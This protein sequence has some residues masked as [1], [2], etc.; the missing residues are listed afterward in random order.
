VEAA[1]R[2]PRGRA[3][4]LPN[5]PREWVLSGFRICLR[6]SVTSCTSSGTVPTESTTTIS[7]TTLSPRA[8]ERVS[9]RWLFP[10]S[11]R[12]PLDRRRGGGHRGG[13]RPVL[14]HARRI[15]GN[16]DE[17]RAARRH[18]MESRR[19][20]L[21]AVMSDKPS[22]SDSGRTAGRRQPGHHRRARVACCGR[23]SRR[24]PRRYT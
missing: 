8:S 14:Q 5:G 20:A 18:R 3:G 2:Q 19:P 15:E 12:Q 13:H 23:V 6:C 1:E 7:S 10:V 24:P 16:L 17:R 22:N 4:R 11:L 21:E 9:G